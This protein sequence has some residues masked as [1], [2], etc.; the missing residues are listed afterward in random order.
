MT[1]TPSS[2]PHRTRTPLSPEQRR[3][4]LAGGLFAGLALCTAATLLP[5]GSAQASPSART[6][7]AAM[8]VAPQPLTVVPRGVPARASRGGRRTV[9]AAHYATR[10]VSKTVPVGSSFSGQ[11]SWYGGSFQG[12]RTA[13]GERF[14][15]HDL[16]AA[17]KTL[18]FGTRLRVCHS[19]R[20]VVVRI[21]D[22]GPYVGSRI[23]DLSQAANQILGFDGVGYV[24]ATPVATRTVAV[25]SVVRPVVK[26][27]PTPKPV[28]PTRPLGPAG[29]AAPV[30]IAAASTSPH[31]RPSLALTGAFALLAT[32]GFR[33][34]R[35][36]S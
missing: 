9:P 26:P 12:Q 22:R 24:T 32:R 25:R 29:P 14:N 17:S 21:N 23:L 10:M 20:C 28:L 36:R 4:R 35:R 27:R 7:V 33:R 5:T 16:T 18:A 15:T 19:G 34:G 2:H 30:L 13:N 11:A 6:Q 3:S 1:P 8:V 31:T